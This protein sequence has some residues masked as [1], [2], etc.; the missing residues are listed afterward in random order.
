MPL[1]LIWK[2]RY[3]SQ[4]HQPCRGF[5]NRPSCLHSGNGFRHLVATPQD[6]DQKNFSQKAFGG[7]G[8]PPQ[9]PK[10]GRSEDLVKENADAKMVMHLSEGRVK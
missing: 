5:Q 7:T 9:V 6:V 3:V 8:S 2:R 4:V 10:K 1:G